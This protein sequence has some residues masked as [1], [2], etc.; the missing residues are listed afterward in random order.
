MTYV[1]DF[2]QKLINTQFYIQPT[3]VLEILLIAFMIYHLLIWMKNTRSW[4]LLKGLSVIL[5]FLAI[6]A[7]L[8]FN[9]ILFIA[10]KLLSVVLLALVVVFQQELRKALEQLGKGNVLVNFISSHPSST[11]K[12]DD[13][14]IDELVEAAYALGKTKTGAL[15]VIERQIPLQEY[16]RTG[17][18]IDALVTSQLLINI[19]EHNTPLHDGAV[20]LR[21]NRI[22]AA[23]C[24]LPLSSN[25][26]ISKELG[27]RHR[28]ALGAS[29]MTDSMTLIVSEETGRVS[30]AS[31]G[32]L[33][34]GITREQL[35]E[36][37]EEIRE[38]EEQRRKLF[39]S[40]KGG[41]MRE[42]KDKK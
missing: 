14:T 20:V 26:E 30:V 24:Y 6:A 16:I 25:Q 35:R 19:F 38:P 5:A 2:F 41:S 39:K 10:N 32:G 29:E 7:L 4:F 18:Q 40:W 42:R 9:T 11:D 8:Q 3:D 23:T 36:I 13:K 22:E 12:F 21:G 37:L 27:T 17:I 33:R 34:L 1:T 31:G 28:A 15:I